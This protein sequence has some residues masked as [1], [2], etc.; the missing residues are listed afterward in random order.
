MTLLL[1]APLWLG[2]TGYFRL[3]SQ[4]EL[5][6]ANTV[7]NDTKRARNDLLAMEVNDLRS[8]SESVVERARLELGMVK[9]DEVVFQFIQDRTNVTLAS[10]TK[11]IAIKNNNPKIEEGR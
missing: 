10:Q 1:Q 11:K 3:K 7:R 4:Q 5:L 2:D 9:S 6:R 8:G